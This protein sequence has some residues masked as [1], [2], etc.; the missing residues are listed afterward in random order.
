MSETDNIKDYWEQRYINE[1]T[2]WDIGE[3][4]A[5]L[6][7]YFDQL[8]NKDLKILIP[9]GGNAH[10]AS[11]LHHAGFTNV[12]VLDIAE[13]PKVNFLSSH[14]DFPAD[15]WIGEDFFQHTGSYDLIVEQTFF[16][17]ID[18]NRRAEYARKCHQLLNN[19]GKLAGVLFNCSFDGGPPFGGTET[20]YRKYFELLFRF[21]IWSAC[22]NS[23]KPREMRELF[24][25]LEKNS[26]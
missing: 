25:I 21:K 1:Q 9:G 2:G 13:Q 15:H 6:K 4:S 3:V 12:Y 19:S 14:P 10:E 17:A 8:Q 16:C 24:I 11:Y 7:E 5:P 20:E 22:Y 23:I 18:P 26:K